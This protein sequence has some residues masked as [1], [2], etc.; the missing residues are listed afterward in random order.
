MV[1]VF[2]CSREYELE[3]QFGSVK[4]TP[5]SGLTT[6]ETGGTA[7]LQIVL[8]YPPKSDVTFSLK[9]GNAA[10]GLLRASGGSCDAVAATAAE[11]C[12]LRFTTANW[13]IPQ[14]VVIVGQDDANQDG[15]VVYK[16]EASA[17]IVSEDGRYNG[18]MPLAVS[19]TNTDNDAGAGF[20]LSRTSGLV[21]SEAP[22]ADTFS[23]RLA[24]QP[25]TDVILDITSSNAAE[26]T[27]APTVVTFTGA[28][29]NTDSTII[30]TGV[31]DQKID[32][33]VA[34]TINIAVRAGSDAAYTPLTPPSVGVTNNNTDIGKYIFMTAA[35]RVTTT[36]PLIGGIPGADAKCDAAKPTGGI[37]KAMLVGSDGGGTLI[38]STS[39]DWVLAANTR[40]YRYG[41]K[42]LV[43]T[44]NGSR[45]FPFNLSN[46]IAPGF[47][48]W[49]GLT[50]TWANNGVTCNAFLGGG[51]TG[52]GTGDGNAVDSKAIND[53]FGDFCSNPLPFLCVEQ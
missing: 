37:Y 28:N 5:S 9:S 13:D 19:V 52:T 30:V 31:A 18:L 44:T 38:R 25:A 21:T 35:Y 47:K 51:G 17:P 26:G 8:S 48:Y 32:G 41:D 12:A 39:T 40:Y 50:T 14:R 24:S 49:T 53:G 45:V 36:P 6:T 20:I 3:A 22:V 29:W 23:I 33:N 46:P 16:I 1:L 10:E 4:I 43:G 11:I 2:G 15:N 34:Y 42:L 27:P 7:T